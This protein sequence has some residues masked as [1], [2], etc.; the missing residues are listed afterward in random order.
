MAGQPKTTSLLAPSVNTEYDRCMLE[1][2]GK[3]EIC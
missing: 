3:G 1:K 2:T